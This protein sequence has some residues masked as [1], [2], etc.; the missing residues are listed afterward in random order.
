MSPTDRLR[1]KLVS[2]SKT[3]QLSARF[4]VIPEFR[5]M[6]HLP[7]RLGEDRALDD[8]VKLI[9][10]SG[11][12]QTIRAYGAALRSLQD[13]IDR[14]LSSEALGAATLLQMHDFFRQHSS[15]QTWAVHAKGAINM[16]K[17]R[18]PQAVKTGFEYSLLQAQL[19]NTTFDALRERQP[20]FLAV[21]EWNAKVSSF[22]QHDEIDGET[23]SW[24]QALA[25]VGVHIP[26]LLCR[27]E[28]LQARKKRLTLVNGND[29]PDRLFSKQL[30]NVRQQLEH[31]LA[32][33]NP[34]SPGSPA[35]NRIQPALLLSAHVFLVAIEYMLMVSEKGSICQTIRETRDALPSESNALL[36]THVLALDTMRALSRH[37]Y[38]IDTVALQ[39]TADM[40]KLVL[41][42]V[43]DAGD[44][45]ATKAEP[46]SVVLNEVYE[47]LS[48][49]PADPQEG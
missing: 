42:R 22:T 48:T 10:A 33:A 35:A 19:G 1:S 49:P 13:S 28:A 24:E 27:F 46:T 47:L 26:G 45:A 21:P 3:G 18:G 40:M 36:S 23:L 38:A 7:R 4:V 31:A 39:S 14:G 32:S 44:N 41:S 9:C 11:L 30:R 12:S 20:C 34:S 6:E 16:L 25:A 15:A 17:A 37:L 29:E 5:I 2:K 8:A 43:L